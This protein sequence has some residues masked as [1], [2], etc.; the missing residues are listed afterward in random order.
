MSQEGCV[1]G[2]VSQEVWA[3]TRAADDAHSRPYSAHQ[4]NARPLTLHKGGGDAATLLS[5]GV[6]VV[7][8]HTPLLR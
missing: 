1:T 3:L 2:G 6:Q 4:V 8:L 7:P 5:R